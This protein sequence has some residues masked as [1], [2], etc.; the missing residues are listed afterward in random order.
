M[1]EDRPGV[2]MNPKHEG[3]PC[4]GQ[5]LTGFV[6]YFKSGPKQL[7]LGGLIDMYI[8]FK[9]KEEFF[10]PYFDKLAGSDQLR[11]Q[12]ES[13]KSEAEIKESWKED[14]AQFKMTREKYLLYQ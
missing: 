14:L 5:N 10:I 11:L 13:G 4:Y 9:G 6:E 7:H 8:Y 1:P 2:A 12:I 3:V